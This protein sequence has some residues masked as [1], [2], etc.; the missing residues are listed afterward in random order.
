MKR[1][2]VICNGESRKGIDLEQ[3]KQYGKV[4]GCN[5]IYRDFTPDA[6]IAVD[7]RMVHQIYWSGY[8]LQNQC[9]FRDWHRMP[10]DAYEMLLQPEMV[11]DDGSFT[12]DMIYSNERGDKKEFVL[13]GIHK[14]RM[15]D[16]ENVTREQDKENVLTQDVYDVL[17]V[18]PGFYI[19]WVEEE[20]K[21]TCTDF[22][23]GGTDYGLSGGPL[24]HLI[25]IIVEEPD[26]IYFIGMD[27]YSNN[28]DRGALRVNNVYKG[29]TGYIGVG[30][31]EVPPDDWIL[32]HKT[33][34]HKFTEVKHF[35]VNKKPLSDPLED[36]VN[37]V[38][39]EWDDT[40]N[41]EYLTY[42]EMFGILADEA[43]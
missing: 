1:V 39:P 7:D 13:H 12:P 16:A 30:G 43:R 3:F 37:R 10:A 6:L 18:N 24:A 35:K 21:V 22:L 38:I 41:L 36:R 28:A 33:I 26:E 8:S 17:F 29:S 11:C 25:S 5:A 15:K 14:N 32:Q 20:D 40:P 34:M 27:L 31:N 19:T 42:A 23:P 9:Y 2:F 4:Y